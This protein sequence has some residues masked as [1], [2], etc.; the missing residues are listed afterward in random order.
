[1]PEPVIK[2]GGD[3]SIRA[4][5]SQD[6]S[7][8][9]ILK[10]EYRSKKKSLEDAE[11]KYDNEKDKLMKLNE[12]INAVEERLGAAQEEIDSDPLPEGAQ[13]R[14]RIHRRDRLKLVDLYFYLP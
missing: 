14:E 7:E 3:A 13:P 10:S 5:A 4:K 2:R 9:G 11:E 8:F 12:E 1:M 6:V